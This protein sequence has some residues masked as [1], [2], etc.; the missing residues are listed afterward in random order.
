MANRNKDGDREEDEIGGREND[1]A[2]EGSDDKEKVVIAASTVA[3]TEMLGRG[4]GGE[5]MRG[6]FEA[7]AASLMGHERATASIDPRESRASLG[8]S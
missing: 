2:N 8:W 3:A 7:V 1:C 6:P 5:D 4:R